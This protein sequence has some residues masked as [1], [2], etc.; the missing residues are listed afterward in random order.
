MNT[1]YQ[2]K[3]EKLCFVQPSIW[4]RVHHLRIGE[5]DLMTMRYPKW[6]SSNAVVEGFGEQWTL[7]KPSFWR[8]RLE[9]TK[10]GQTM[11]FATFEPEGWKGGGTFRLPNG[12]RI[13][14]RF[15]LWKNLN[16]IYSQQKVRL[17]SFKRES[18]WK[19]TIL[20]TLEHESALLEK[21]PWILMSVYHIILE[22]R[23]QS[24]GA[25]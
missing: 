16:E 2:Y 9:C 8:S 17:A 10:Q 6:Y 24:R 22:R 20:L 19:G 5:T 25:A 15:D 18:I 21:H 3:N 1:I 13:E 4:K 14:Y 11:P 12:E 7:T 23:Q